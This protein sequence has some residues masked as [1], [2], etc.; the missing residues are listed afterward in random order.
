MQKIIERDNGVS[1]LVKLNSDGS[2]TTGTIQD[3]TPILERAQAMHNEGY[4][5]SADMRL[6]ASIPMVVIEKYLN[7]NN[8]LM[9]EFMNNKDHQ[10]RLLNDPALSYFRVWRGMV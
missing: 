10:R 3:C 4:H 1:T 2:L 6:A 7:D 8:L 9:S 5:G